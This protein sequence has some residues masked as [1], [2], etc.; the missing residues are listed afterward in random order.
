MILILTSDISCDIYTPE[1][2]RYNTIEAS[3]IHE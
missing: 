3:C 2:F 1:L